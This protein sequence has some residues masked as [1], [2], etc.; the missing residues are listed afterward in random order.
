MQVIFA[1][2]F[3]DSNSFKMAEMGCYHCN[4]EYDFYT[5]IIGH[6]ARFGAIMF[7]IYNYYLRSIYTIIFRYNFD[8]PVERRDVLCNGPA[9]LSLS[10]S[11]CL[12]VC[13][14]IRPSVCPPVRPKLIVNA[15]S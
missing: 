15:I 5:V 7:K 8:T 4:F 12:S 3:S 10:L 14:S 6:L 1:F 2:E 13:L 9:C 11:I